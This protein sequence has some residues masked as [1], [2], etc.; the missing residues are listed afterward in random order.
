MLRLGKVE[1]GDVLKLMTYS[2]NTLPQSI[3]VKGGHLKADRNPLLK[4]RGHIWITRTK[5]W[6]IEAGARSVE[7]QISRFEP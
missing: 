1:I 3:S 2:G 7:I 6:L 4:G 5:S